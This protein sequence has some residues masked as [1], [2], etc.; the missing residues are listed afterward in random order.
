MRICL[1]KT[2]IESVSKVTLPVLLT[3][4]HFELPDADSFVLPHNNMLCQ[5]QPVVMMTV[6]KVS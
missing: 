5:D 2:F 3:K 4:F 6:R 1:G